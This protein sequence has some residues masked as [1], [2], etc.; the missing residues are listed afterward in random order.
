[1]APLAGTVATVVPRDADEDVIFIV[2]RP[3][4]WA[5]LLLNDAGHAGR[6]A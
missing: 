6:A 1:M 5:R 4:R 2:F 3:P